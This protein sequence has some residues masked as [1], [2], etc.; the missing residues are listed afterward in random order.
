MHGQNYTEMAER[1]GASFVPLVLTFSAFGYIPDTNLEFLSFVSVTGNALHLN[2]WPTG[3]RG[4]RAA[5]N[6]LA[7]VCLRSKSATP[8]SSPSPPSASNP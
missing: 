6:I 8:I 2:S 7:S 5:M 1:I 3:P 4:L